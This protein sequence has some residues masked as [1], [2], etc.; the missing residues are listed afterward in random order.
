[1]VSIL[2]CHNLGAFLAASNCDIALA[3][4]LALLNELLAGVAQWYQYYCVI[5]LAH[6]LL[7]V[8]VI[9]RLP[10]TLLFLMS[11][12][13]A[14]FWPKLTTSVLGLMHLTLPMM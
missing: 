13:L 6:F 2:L 7:P 4:H 5:T 8:T 9:L 3:I 12:L 10:F 11:F 1:M 14:F